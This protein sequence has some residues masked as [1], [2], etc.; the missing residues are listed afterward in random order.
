MGW[1]PPN[2]RHRG[3][4]LGAHFALLRTD[5]LLTL[6][7]IGFGWQYQSSTQVIQL[8]YSIKVG[9]NDFYKIIEFS[10]VPSNITTVR[11]RLL[12]EIVYNHCC[13]GI[14]SKDYKIRYCRA[15]YDSPPLS[16]SSP[17][18]NQ[19]LGSSD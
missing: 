13:V 11:L 15:G 9:A 12:N 1:T 3:A 5:F 17:S 16:P 6:R 8:L 19:S 14:S 18:E 10:L 2:Y 7:V 4:R